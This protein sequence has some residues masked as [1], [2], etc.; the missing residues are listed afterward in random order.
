MKKASIKQEIKSYSTVDEY[1]A[2]FPSDKKQ[3]LEELRRIIKEVI[4][5]AKEVISYQMPAF[6]MKKVL[7][8]FAL[9]RHHIGFYPTNSGIEKFKAEFGAYKYS[10][11]ALQL[12]LDEPL[13]VSLIQKIVKFKAEED[14]ST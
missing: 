7:V 8:Y 1:L 4:P 9:H 5:D 10:K 2:T 3:K 6:K 11:G 12:P 14:S 13:P